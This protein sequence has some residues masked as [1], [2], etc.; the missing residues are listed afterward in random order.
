[1]A[2]K[3]EAPDKT[4]L[5]GDASL[6]KALEKQARAELGPS[7]AKLK[8]SQKNLM[9]FGTTCIS[10]LYRYIVKSNLKLEQAGAELSIA[11]LSSA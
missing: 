5:L 6:R 4:N 3:L 9:L 7:L 1:M 2:V 8:S 11:K 10:M